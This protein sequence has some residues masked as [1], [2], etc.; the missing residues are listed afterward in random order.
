MTK[1][2]AEIREFI[3]TQ[4]KGVKA[5]SYSGLAQAIKQRY[6]VELSKAT[7]SKRAKTL[8]V[9]FR[10][11]RRRLAPVGKQPAHSV[12]LDCAGAFFLKGAEL[13]MGLLTALNRL[14]STST[15]SEQAKKALKLAQRI[16]ATLLYG[17]IFGLK[18]ADDIAG[19]QRRGLLYLTGQKDLTTPRLRQAGLPSQQ[20]ISQYLQFLGG[21]KMLRLLIKEALKACAGALFLAIDFAGQTLY[22]DAQ[23][24]TVWADFKKIPRDFGTTLN[25]ATSYVR[26]VF[27]SPSPRRPLVLQNLP[28]YTFLPTEFFNLI[29]CLEQAHEQPISR[30]VAM[31]KSGAGLKF[32]QDLKPPRKCLFLAPLS[33]W[34]YARL[35]G[36]KIV[37]DF[38]QYRIGPQREEMAVADA[39]VNLVNSQ[40]RKNIRVRAALI[41]RKEERLALITNISRR[42]ERYIR[43]IAELYFRRWPAEKLK[44]FFDILEEAHEQQLGH[45]K[46]KGGTTPL[47]A[48]DYDKRPQEG[49]RLFLEELHRYARVRF[50]P[51]EYAEK[52]LQ[53]MWQAFYRQSGYLKLGQ[54]SCE[55]ILQPFSQKKL[56]KDA[57]EACRRFNQSG[58]DFPAGKRLRISLQSRE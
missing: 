27:E 46:D 48:I 1:V 10:R 26:D 49:F 11:G 45:P 15:E 42:Q 14:L 35:S 47:A 52:D 31:D 9:G 24:R 53:S 19:Y 4:L 22:L 44:T 25:K 17:P 8:G 18:A 23:A 36:S 43:R 50:F 2:T 30:I 39:D 29:D 40:L 41:R 34:Q 57:Q 12:F 16:N 33:P 37:R 21:R 56:Q 7:L 28:G 5:P 55:I 3:Q 32:W 13:E 58:L 51:S 6:G 20:E 54:D 38:R